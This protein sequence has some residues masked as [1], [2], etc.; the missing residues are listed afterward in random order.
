MNNNFEIRFLRIAF[1]IITGISL[2]SHNSY[3]DL[4]TISIFLTGELFDR[5]IFYIDFNPLNINALINSQ[6]NID[7]DEKERG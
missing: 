7:R 2:I 3:P 6:L 1:L 4:V 5:I